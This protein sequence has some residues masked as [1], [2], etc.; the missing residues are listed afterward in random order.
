[1]CINKHCFFFYIELHSTSLFYH[2]LFELISCFTKK[3]HKRKLYIF[4]AQDNKHQLNVLR[5]LFACRR[6][7]PQRSKNITQLLH[8][9]FIYRNHTMI[10][11]DTVKC[12]DATRV[13]FFFCFLFLSLE[14]YTG[15]NVR[16]YT[17]L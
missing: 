2:R 12:D 6:A 5:G 7:K 14:R 10:P 3:C 8:H 17:R 16:V 9:I 13:V 1:M 11:F 15:N 4:L